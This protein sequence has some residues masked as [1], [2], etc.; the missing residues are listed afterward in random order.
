MQQAE[1]NWWGT[2]I[3]VSTVTTVGDAE[4]SW[5]MGYTT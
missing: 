2:L 5:V 1:A 4:P 3:L